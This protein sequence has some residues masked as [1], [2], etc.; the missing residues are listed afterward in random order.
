VS[1]G[2]AV[3]PSVEGDLDRIAAI[4][5]HHVLSGLGSF[6]A[7]PPGGAEMARRRDDALARGLPF[8]VAGIDGQVTGFA[9]AAPYRVRPAN[10]STPE[11]SMYV[12]HARAG[13]GIGR[14][15]RGRLIDEC[16]R[17]GYRQRVAVIGDS[18]NHGSI[19][20]HARRGFARVGLLPAVGYEFGRRAGGVLMQR[21]LGDGDRTP[22]VLEAWGRA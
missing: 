1:E 7:V 21:A 4:Y 18:G 19:A 15:L 10:R 6:E 12:D 9:Y 22:P 20:L 3:R 11:D 2:I 17:L 16:A 14:A 8:L 5:V 13:R